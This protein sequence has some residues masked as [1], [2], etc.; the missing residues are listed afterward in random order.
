ML[1]TK[2]QNTMNSKRVFCVYC[3]E[4]ARI[5]WMFSGR[6]NLLYPVSIPASIS[7]VL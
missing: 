5:V 2:G 4:K 1:S 7:S 6:F 3:I